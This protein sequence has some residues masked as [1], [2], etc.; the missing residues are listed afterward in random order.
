M[1]IIRDYLSAFI[2]LFCLGL[3]CPDELE[4]LLPWLDY[5]F[6]TLFYRHCLYGNNGDKEVHVINAKSISVSDKSNRKFG[7]Q[8]L[9]KMISKC[10]RLATFAQVLAKTWQIL[11]QVLAKLGKASLHL[12]FEM[13]VICWSSGEPKAK[14][15]Q[16]I[17]K[18]FCLPPIENLVTP[19]CPP[20]L[21]AQ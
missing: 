5:V 6:I 14:T 15:L 3:F 20:P 18:R 8:Y 2:G 11:N 4:P 17:R 12:F 21:R 1:I 16:K 19:N 13:F 9:F 10:L 7:Y